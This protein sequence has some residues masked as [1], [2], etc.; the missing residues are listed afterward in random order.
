MTQNNLKIAITGGIG[1][2]KSTVLKLIEGEGF[3]VFSCDEIYS[4]LL[5]NKDFI[6]LLAAAFGNEI[7]QNGNLDRRKLADIAFN[8]QSALKKLN[9]ITHP[10]I[11]EEVQKRMTLHELSFCEVPLLF[12]NGFEA[13]FN[14]V[15]VVLRD[16]EERTKS[17][18]DR[19][20]I[21]EKEAILRMNNQ[22]DYDNYDFTKYYVI[23]NNGKCDDL[24][25]AV[26]S[27]LQKILKKN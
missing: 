14:K 5:K 2:G 6:N 21:A 4:D 1:S 26:K 23:H 16:R 19:D 27:I 3:A 17:I 11:M 20:N 8:S 7:L 9:A 10:K 13:L 15:I 12:E 25:L 18:V 22:I 24:R